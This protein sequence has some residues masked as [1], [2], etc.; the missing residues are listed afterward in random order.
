MGDRLDVMMDGGIQRG[1]DVVKAL[2]MGADV[3]A[4]GKLQGWG[5]AAARPAGLV[6][7][8][9][10]PK[11]R[12]GRRPSGAWVFVLVAETAGEA[13]SLLKQLGEAGPV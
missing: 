7:V 3:V 8:A 2:A 6:N 11:V 9:G 13:N 4:I 10:N 12:F 5:L 1:G